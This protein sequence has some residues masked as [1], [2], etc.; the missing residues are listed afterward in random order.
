MRCGSS[1]THRIW[2]SPWLT[3]YVWNNNYIHFKWRRI[4]SLWI[5]WEN[6]TR[7]LITCVI[8]QF[9]LPHFIFIWLFLNSCEHSLKVHLISFII[10]GLGLIHH[11][12][13]IFTNPVKVDFFFTLI[14]VFCLSSLWLSIIHEV[15]IMK[16]AR[17]GKVLL[18]ERKCFTLRYKVILQG[19][20]H[21]NNLEKRDKWLTETFPSNLQF[22]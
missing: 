13:F 16:I 17:K 18:M 2:Q 12:W 22:N 5:N 15:I 19:K 3:N 8:S 20:L 10:H 9:A 4:N 6:F 1:L 7:S 21:Y 14:I 11:A